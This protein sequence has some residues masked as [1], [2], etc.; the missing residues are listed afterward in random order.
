METRIVELTSALVAFPTHEREQEAQEFLAGVL[1]AC[2]FACRLQEVAP[3]RPNLIA[4][5]GSSGP[6]LCSHIDVH[7]PHGHPDPFT[8]R[9]EGDT[10]V[11]RGVLDAKGQI[12]AIVAACEARPDADALVLI[13]CDEEYGGIGSERAEIPEGPWETE[14]GIVCEP[15]GFTICTAQ[16]G[17]VDVHVEAR[18]TGGHAYAPDALGSPVHAVLAA[19]EVLDTCRF[20]KARHGL[21]PQPRV[22]IGRIAGGEHAWRSPAAAELDATMG[23]LPGTDLEDAETEVEE[24]L[25]DLALRWSSR[26]VDLSYEISDSSEPVE[27]PDDLPIVE[28]LA[29]AAG[30]DPATTGMPSWTDAAYL[31]LKHGVPCAVFGAG[32]LTSAHSDRETVAIDDL[33]RLGRVLARLLDARGPVHR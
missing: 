15:T 23:V 31:F 28:R 33:V 21:L 18:G 6:L 16:M 26:G 27:M 29:A 2:G 14:G 4:R 1:R 9:R 19:V 3:G 13:T 22:N 11:G 32:E 24:R 5:R 30:I 25:G 8:A 20:L 12:A 10:L 17:N 7:L